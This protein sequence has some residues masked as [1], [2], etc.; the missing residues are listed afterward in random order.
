MLRTHILK[1]AGRRH[2]LILWAAVRL[3]T[4]LT[5][6]YC[7]LVGPVPLLGAG[8]LAD[9]AEEALQTGDGADRDAL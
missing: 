9:D 1:N 6:V 4:G 7:V 8:V 2:M 3:V 5:W